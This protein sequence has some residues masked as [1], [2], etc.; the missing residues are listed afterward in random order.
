MFEWSADFRLSTPLEEQN[1]STLFVITET[2][3]KRPGYKSGKTGVD[4]KIAESW[5][6]YQRQMS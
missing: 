4:I 5:N 1:P 6:D 2:L 3:K